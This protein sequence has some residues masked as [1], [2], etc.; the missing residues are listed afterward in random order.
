VFSVIQGVPGQRI[1]STHSPHVVS[2][3]DVFDIRVFRRDE[4]GTRVSWLEENDPAGSPRFR[5]EELEH[6]RRFVQRHHG[7]VLFARV[8]ALF[9]GDTEEAALPAFAQFKWPGGADAVGV[10]MLN[11]EGAGNYKH[12]VC[13]LSALGIPWVIFSDGDQAAR[14][15]LAAAGTAMGRTLDESSPEVVML[16]V[17]QN[18]E[19]Y[20]IGQGCRPAAQAAMERFFGASALEEFRI[21]NNGQQ[22]PKGAGVRDYTSAGWEDRLV[23][24]FMV[25][26]KG[27]YG[28][29]LAEE[30]VAR[31]QLPNSIGEFFAKIDRVLG[32][33]NP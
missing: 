22:L 6:L 16:P 13:A 5:P 21:A 4:H 20:L 2:V 18:F 25:K 28:R 33:V 23:H 32:R 31:G 11:V 30:I 19:A 14:Q 8:V 17:G 1:I 26:H 29:P 10:S 15:G 24:D 27:T 9:E 3:A 7:E 12:V